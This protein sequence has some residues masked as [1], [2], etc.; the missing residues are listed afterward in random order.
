MV[1]N[2]AVLIAFTAH[3]GELTLR[4]DAIS[5]V[6]VLNILRLRRCERRGAEQQR[7][8]AGSHERRESTPLSVHGILLWMC[9]LHPN[10]N[11]KYI[12]NQRVSGVLIGTQF[13]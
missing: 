13:D 10:N 9:S 5:R 2:D 4:R 11:G 12:A 7:Q 6:V 1:E 8:A 3:A